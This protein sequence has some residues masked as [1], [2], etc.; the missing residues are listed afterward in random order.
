MGLVILAL[1]AG[2]TYI[3]GKGFINIY[4]HHPNLILFIAMALLPAIAL[5][6]TGSVLYHLLT[7]VVIMTT[8]YWFVRLAT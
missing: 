4:L 7:G 2:T 8:H 6:I 3:V 5:G 1:T